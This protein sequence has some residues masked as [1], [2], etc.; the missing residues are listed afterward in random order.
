MGI[1]WCHGD[2]AAYYAG[3]NFAQKAESLGYIVIYPSVTT[4]DGCWDVSSPATLTHLGGG[5]SLAIHSMVQ[6]TAAKYNADKTRI[7]AVGTSSG[8]MMTNVLLGAY[9]DVFAAGSSWAGVPFGCFAGPTTWSGDCAEG[10]IDKTPAQWG[11]AV[12]AAY[13]GFTG[14]RPK[15]QM[16]HGTD[17][18]VL[19][20][21]NFGE[22]VEQ[23]T[24]VLGISAT[25]DSTEVGKP[26][27]GMTRMVYGGG[28]L[29]AVIEHGMSHNLVVLPDEGMRI[30]ASF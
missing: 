15:M 1:H 27:S 30:S 22:G 20:Y 17:D 3:T 24:N 16:F 10:L 29:E 14:K 26:Q 4:S 18:D 7:F 2:A 21:E 12:R 8:A 11:D 9:P 6:Y 23:W 28:K 5:D 13:P 25:P 19:A